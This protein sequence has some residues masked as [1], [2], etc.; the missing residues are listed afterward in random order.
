MCFFGEGCAVKFTSELS[1]GAK[2]PSVQFEARALFVYMHAGKNGEI[3]KARTVE[4]Y[5][6][7]F[8]CFS[9]RIGTFANWGAT[10]KRQC[11]LERGIEDK[12][13]ELVDRLG[14]ISVSMA[15]DEGGIKYYEGREFIIVDS[16]GSL[17]W[18]FPGA[19]KY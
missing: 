16:E 3:S 11:N 7:L 10:A 12:M 15:P 19:R 1:S 18:R 5:M 13:D 9:M 14:G 8:L 4:F 17:L 2:D 6:L